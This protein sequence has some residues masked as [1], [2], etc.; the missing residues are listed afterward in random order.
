M[1]HQ[2]KHKIYTMQPKIGYGVIFH[3][4]L[5]HWAKYIIYNMKWG[6]KIWDTT[7]TSEIKR[8]RK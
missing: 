5:L 2:Q 4:N 1:R 3:H 8:R 7:Q 6:E